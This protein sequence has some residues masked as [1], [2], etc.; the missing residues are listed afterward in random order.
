MFRLKA[1]TEMEDKCKK[2]LLE[3][4]NTAFNRGYPVFTD[5]LDLNEQNIYHHSQKELSFVPARLWGGY[6]LAERQML[7]FRPDALS[8]SDSDLFPISCLQIRFVSAKFAEQLTHR[9]YLG[10][11]MNLGID[12]SK[13]GDILVYDNGA[14]VICEQ[15]MASWISRE[16]TRVRHTQVSCSVTACKDIA[17]QPKTQEIVGTVSSVRLD[18]LL[19]LLWKGSRSLLSSCISGGQVYVNGKLITES[20]FHPKE[21]DLISVR[22]HGKARFVNIGDKTRK[23]RTLVVLEKYI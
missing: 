1:D 17:F 14:D 5:F 15:T 18:A 12:R 3:L 6:D 19:P 16:L 22:G 4:A 13:T 8:L 7:A 2:R 10:S 11:L 9:D 23:G 21:G 20:G